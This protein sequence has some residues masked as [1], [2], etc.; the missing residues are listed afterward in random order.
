M[1]AQAS[2]AKYTTWYIPSSSRQEVRKQNIASQLLSSNLHPPAVEAVFDNVLCLQTIP[3]LKRANY[4][5][6]Q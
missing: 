3:Y 5:H 1:L 2:D 6:E 4:Y